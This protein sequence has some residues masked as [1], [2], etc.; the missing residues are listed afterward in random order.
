MFSSLIV[1]AFLHFLYLEG[2]LLYCLVS[3]LGCFIASKDC[4]KEEVRQVKA[5]S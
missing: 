4:L 1:V 5:T 2:R 3:D